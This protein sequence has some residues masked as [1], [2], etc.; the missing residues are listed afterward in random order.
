MEVEKVLRMNGGTQRTSYAAN[1]TLQSIVSMKGRELL[2]ESIKRM[3]ITLLPN[4]F[5][6]ADLGCSAGPNSLMMVKEVINMV[7]VMS[8]DLNRPAPEFRVFLNDLPRNDFS[9]LT[10]ALPNFHK[11]IEEEKGTEF[12]PCLVSV[13]PKSFYRRLLPSKSVN[14]FH[15]CYS[16]HFL[17]KVPDGLVNADGE[18]L[19]KGN[20]YIAKTSPPEVWKAY[21]AQF[22]SD[23]TSFL[24]LRSKE[25]VP[26]GCMVLTLV[27]SRRSDDPDN[28][29]EFMGITLHDM[30]SQGL[31]DEAKLDSFNIP[32]YT[33]MAKEVKELIHDEGSFILDGL[34]T[35]GIDWDVGCDC[36]SLGARAQYVSDTM[37]AVAE[38]M[39]A[40]HF[41]EQAMDGFFSRFTA[42][43]ASL[44]ASRKMEHFSIVVALRRENLESCLDL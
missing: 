29:F 35:F 36:P 2:K 6:M 1:S 20:I 21:N 19:N 39:I 24:T 42:T 23:F 30:V 3:Y 13:I 7:D 14:F 40:S 22:K 43:A 10:K 15:S 25:M 26:G 11:M 31:I 37:R 5:V 12:G 16:N 38:P 28:V 27:G 4:R 32:Y 17:S 8:R 44:M 18:P 33:P 34:Q 9:T 41:G